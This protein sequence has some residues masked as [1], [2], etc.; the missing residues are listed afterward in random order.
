MMENFL[1]LKLQ[2]GIFGILITK[3]WKFFENQKEIEK[4]IKENPLPI[5]KG[6]NN[7]IYQCFY[8]NENLE[9]K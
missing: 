9:M 7:L 4:F 6:D 3:G 1:L 5:D 8:L 2:R